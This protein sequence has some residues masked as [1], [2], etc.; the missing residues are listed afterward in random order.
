MQAPGLDKPKVSSDLPDKINQ[1]MTE[2]VTKW[3]N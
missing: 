3:L 1:A 2:T